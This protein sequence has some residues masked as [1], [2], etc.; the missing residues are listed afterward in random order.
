M[1]ATI[2]DLKE[3]VAE[4]ADRFP[5]LSD[6]NLFVVWYLLA[7][8]VEDEKTAAEAVVGGA[9]DKS[10]DAVLVDDDIRCVFVVQAKYRQKL[11]VTTEGRPD[12]V[13]FADLVGTLY[14]DAADFN[15]YKKKCDP[16][17]ADRMS[18][19]RERILKRGYRVQL[20][21]VTLGRC[22]A[23]LRD[24]AADLVKRRSARKAELHL[25]DG[26]QVISLLEDYLDG[27]APPVPLLELPFLAGSTA[28]NQFDPDTHIDSW[29]FTMRGND[30][31]SLFKRAGIRLFAR[32]VRGFLGDTNIN[33]AMEITLAKEPHFFWYFNNGVTIVCDEAVKVQKQ[34]REILEVRNPQV[35]N[36]QQTTRVLD[37]APSAGKAGVLVRVIQ[38][39]RGDG[40][41]ARRFDLLV[42]R[43]VQ[44]TNWQNAIRPSDLMSNDRQ[45]VAIGREFRK[46]GYHYLRKRQTK[47]EAKRAAKGQYRFMVKKEELAQA[48]G[49]CLFD[50]QVV[51]RGKEHLFDEDYYKRIFVSAEADY[52]LM[53]YWLLR[54]VTHVSRGY[55][56]RAYAKWVVMHF[57]WS[58]IGKLVETY[59][60][61]FVQACEARKRDAAIF[62]PLSSATTL[63]F[64]VA[65]QL[66]RVQRGTGETAQDVSTFFARKGLH[67]EMAAMWAVPR[68]GQR[69]RFDGY[70][71]KFA[72]ALKDAAQPKAA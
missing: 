64:Q 67:K 23:A 8:L 18:T 4:L 52:Y 56:E 51:R 35:I 22:S 27:V 24:E 29:V 7:S 58:E 36:G 55:P 54:E 40:E 43:I 61:T 5:K 46:V 63:A 31:G 33:S 72:S 25:L 34:G 28:L 11:K 57:M 70:V 13:A 15:A 44:A 16:L 66:F 1:K 3:Q 10:V 32:N 39:P 45:Q 30:V 6:D 60:R 2:D 17:V 21:Y 26:A 48:V 14:G 20:H 69:S 12:V 68:A 71:T 65:L 42:S 47:R 41:Q 53:R 37:A 38:V 62:G 19:A 49:A 50:P 9:G 59:P